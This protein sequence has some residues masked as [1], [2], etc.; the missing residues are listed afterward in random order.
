MV[1]LNVDQKKPMNMLFSTCLLLQRKGKSERWTKVMKTE[2]MMR[3]Q[4]LAG[5]NVSGNIKRFLFLKF[6][7]ILKQI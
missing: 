7:L 6:A 2:I 4:R 5:P 1:F 3:S